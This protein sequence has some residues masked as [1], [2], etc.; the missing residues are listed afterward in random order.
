MQTCDNGIDR[1]RKRHTKDIAI[2]IA[3]TYIEFCQSVSTGVKYPVA[4][5]DQNLATSI[6]VYIRYRR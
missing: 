2:M 5:C 4:G 6:I 3:N 1:C